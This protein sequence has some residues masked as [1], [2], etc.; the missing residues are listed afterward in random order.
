M[1]VRICYPDS[2]F[3]L[4]DDDAAELGPGQM[5][6]SQFLDELRTASC[7]AADAELQ[8]V[9]RSTEACPYIARAFERYRTFEPHRLERGLRRYAPEAAGATSAREYIDAVGARVGRAV[10]L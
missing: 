5:R 4:V 10:G 6:K 3:D 2:K 9:G 1:R 8:R 7:T